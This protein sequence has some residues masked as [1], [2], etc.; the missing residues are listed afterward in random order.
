LAFEKTLDAY[1]TLQVDPAA[2]EVVIR[3]AYHAL[4]RRYH[5]DG[6]RPDARRMAE[7]NY[8][9]DLVRDEIRRQAYDQRR[10]ELQV[11]DAGR[12]E[13]MGPGATQWVAKP[14][15]AGGASADGASRLSPYAGPLTR[16]REAGMTDD[17]ARLDFGRY[18]GW[19]L[20]DL[21]RHDPDYLRWLSRHSSG[22]RFRGEILQLLPDEAAMAGR[23]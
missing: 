13:P 23:R 1:A 6:D 15:S 11:H 12:K 7:L 17:S 22:V 18:T 5:P 8:A 9:Y 2:H 3:A 19:S 16:A 21:A 20:R 10:R 14:A 4:A